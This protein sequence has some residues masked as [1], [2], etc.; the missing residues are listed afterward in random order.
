MTGF[1]T[2]LKAG[3]DRSAA[4]RDVQLQMLRSEKRKHPYYW[5]SFILSGADGP[6]E[7]R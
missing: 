1:Y 7:L 6:I 5:A 4:L 3:A 2:N